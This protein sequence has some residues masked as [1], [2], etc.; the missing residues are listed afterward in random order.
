[1]FLN[2][3]NIE[4]IK[5]V[6]RLAESQGLTVAQTNSIW[7]RYLV[8]LRIYRTA[9]DKGHPRRALWSGTSPQELRQYL[10]SVHGEAK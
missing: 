5:Q 9:E 3:R 8:A 10:T 2:S 1:M 4:L 6:R 7:A